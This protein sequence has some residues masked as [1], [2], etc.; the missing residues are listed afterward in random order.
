MVA[1]L[2]PFL[3]YSANT[4]VNRCRSSSMVNDPRQR[5]VSKLE[6]VRVQQSALRAFTMHGAAELLLLLSCRSQNSFLKT[7]H[8]SVDDDIHDDWRSFAARRLRISH[9]LRHCRRSCVLLWGLLRGGPI[10]ASPNHQ[11]QLR[12][13]Y[14]TLSVR[15]KVRRFT[16][17]GRRWFWR[18]RFSTKP[19][20]LLW[21]E[22]YS[23]CW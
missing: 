21:K 17:Y 6:R 5:K 18:S 8:S 10:A 15:A 1:N 14:V 7:Q 4:I 3:R 16:Q 9:R 19:P 20:S 23:R 12:L 11:H 2:S 13:V 22:V